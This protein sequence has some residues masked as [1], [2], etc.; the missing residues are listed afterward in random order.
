MTNAGQ[1]QRVVLSGWAPAADGGHVTR[2]G[3]SWPSLDEGGP[4]TW[5]VWFFPA[6]AYAETHAAALAVAQVLAVALSVNVT[7]SDSFAVAVR[8]HETLKA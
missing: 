1:G 5:R 6:A 2:R 3:I 8:R 4:E 7:A